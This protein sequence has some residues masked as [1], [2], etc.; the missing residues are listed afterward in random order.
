M[1]VINITASIAVRAT[2]L[3]YLVTV[4]ALQTETTEIAF[5]L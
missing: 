2:A 4:A 5:S 1:L 3:I